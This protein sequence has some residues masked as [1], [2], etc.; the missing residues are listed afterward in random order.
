MFLKVVAT[1]KN[2]SDHILAL[3]VKVLIY[4][5]CTVTLIECEQH[6]NNKLGADALLTFAVWMLSSVKMFA[7]KIC[8]AY[9]C[10]VKGASDFLFL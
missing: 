7:E 4:K 5:E 3:K 2:I 9:T 1:V 6:S 10:S 8:A